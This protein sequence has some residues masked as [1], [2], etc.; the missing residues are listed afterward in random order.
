L[1]IRQRTRSDGTVVE[2]DD[3]AGY[4][5]VEAEGEPAGS[6]GQRQRY[7]VHCTRIADGSRHL[8]VGQHVTFRVAPGHNGRWE[9]VEV[10]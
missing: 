6:G 2:Y 1:T 5:W 4:G 9:A 7:F 8:D 3:H 10:A